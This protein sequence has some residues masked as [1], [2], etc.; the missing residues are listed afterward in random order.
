MRVG[1]DGW[2]NAGAQGRTQ[3]NRGNQV[4]IF[5]KSPHVFTLW[6]SAR[7]RC[8]DIDHC[9]CFN[10]DAGTVCSLDERV[11]LGTSAGEPGYTAQQQNGHHFQ[12]TTRTLQPRQ[13]EILALKLLKAS[14]SAEWNLS[15]SCPVEMVTLISRSLSR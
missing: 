2:T 13:H 14:V 9:N 5:P 6:Q 7:Y 11:V 15:L 8:G 4:L 3:V 10:C 12:S 1:E